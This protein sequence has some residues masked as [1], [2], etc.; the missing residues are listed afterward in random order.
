MFI[1]LCNHLL[2]PYL[3]NF[4]SSYREHD[5]SVH[6]FSFFFLLY[7]SSDSS[8]FLLIYFVKFMPQYFVFS[9]ANG[10]VFNIKL[11]MFSDSI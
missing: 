8:S 2:P 1:L 5:L 10:N 11:Q 6:L 7:L 3:D 4:K 9:V